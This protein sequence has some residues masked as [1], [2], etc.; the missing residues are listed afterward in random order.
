[1]V[2]KFHLQ[3]IVWYL[4]RQ[5]FLIFLRVSCTTGRAGSRLS[6]QVWKHRLQMPVV[7]SSGNPQDR[8]GVSIQ[9][10]L[11]PHSDPFKYLLAIKGKSCTVS[12]FRLVQESKDIHMVMT[13]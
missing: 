11:H 6:N 12:H 7:L 1:M 2:I 4:H 9:S 10:E 5:V 3:G 13:D 8:H